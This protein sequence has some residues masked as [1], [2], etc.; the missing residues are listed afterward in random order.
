MKTRPNHLRRCRICGKPLSCYNRM[1]IC[2]CHYT[3]PSYREP[4]ADVRKHAGAAA[5]AEALYEGW[6]KRR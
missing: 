5:H 6:H 4:W 2:F 3:I 1:D